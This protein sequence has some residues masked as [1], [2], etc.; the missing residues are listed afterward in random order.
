MSNDSNDKGL[1]DY[2]VSGEVSVFFFPHAV[3]S[4][5]F[6]IQLVSWSRILCNLV[7]TA[8]RDWE[9]QLKVEMLRVSRNFLHRCNF[10]F[11]SDLVIIFGILILT[12]NIGQGVDSNYCDKQGFTL[13]HL[14]CVLLMSSLW[15]SYS[16]FFVWF[17]WLLVYKHLIIQHC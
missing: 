4:L 12:F 9:K 6:I 1:S 17:A 15:L 2:E 3:P 14:V 10:S 8:Y 7:F 11:L 16:S 5:F 13:L